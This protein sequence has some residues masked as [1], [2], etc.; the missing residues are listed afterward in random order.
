MTNFVES[1]SASVP[2]WSFWLA[3]AVLAFSGAL[4]MVRRSTN[5]DA[6]F[7]GFILA[8]VILWTPSITVMSFQGGVAS[9]NEYFESLSPKS[10]WVAALAALVWMVGGVVAIARTWRTSTGQ[11][12]T[13]K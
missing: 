4:F 1:L 7:V 9:V 10:L 3:L 11:N 13:A 6:L 8:G 2:A 5:A 12:S